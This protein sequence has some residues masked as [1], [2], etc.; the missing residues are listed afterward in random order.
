MTGNKIISGSSDATLRI[1]ELILDRNE[2]TNK[3][4]A[5]L[6]TF[7]VLKDGHRSDILCVE[8]WE[9][10]VVSAGADSTV[11]VW[12]MAGDLLHRL[13][14]HLG[15]VRYL[16]IDEFKCVTGGDAKRIMVWD[17]KVSGSF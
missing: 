17:Y 9:D 7:T 1:W 12:T 8:T 3:K 15:N 5:C 16:Y 4:I 11:I 10:Y 6:N 13:G 14:G 2:K